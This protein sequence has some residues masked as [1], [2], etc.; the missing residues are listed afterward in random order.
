VVSL[1]VSFLSIIR[2]R[3]LVCF[4]FVRLEVTA[5]A[6]EYALFKESKYSSS[7]QAHTQRAFKR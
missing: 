1:F 6:S 4:S 7:L 5:D 3:F 2:V